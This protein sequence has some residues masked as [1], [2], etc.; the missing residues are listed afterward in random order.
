MSCWRD[1]GVQSMVYD[2]EEKALSASFCFSM[3][4]LSP[5]YTR[6]SYQPPRLPRLYT[7][8]VSWVFSSMTGS[9]PFTMMFS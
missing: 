9:L 6:T 8:K 4:S 2:V 5:S 3:S 1:P 7:L